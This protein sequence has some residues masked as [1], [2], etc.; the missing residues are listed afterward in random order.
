MHTHIKAIYVGLTTVYCIK[1]L[2]LYM[3][4]IKYISRG[5]C[6]A[7]ELTK[8]HAENSIDIMYKSV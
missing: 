6:L 4:C 8:M 2:Y 3:C 5:I 7:G 1:T